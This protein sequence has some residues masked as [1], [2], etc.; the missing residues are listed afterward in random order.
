V[1]V[2]RLRA[3]IAKPAIKKIL[4]STEWRI[5]NPRIAACGV[6]LR[7]VPAFYTAVYSRL[8]F[9]EKLALYELSRT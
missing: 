1:V 4:L 3:R 8:H 7:K 9:F 6:T 5:S 2:Q